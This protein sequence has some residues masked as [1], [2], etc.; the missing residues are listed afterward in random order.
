MCTN[1]NDI[2]MCQSSKWSQPVNDSVSTPLHSTYSKC[3]LIGKPGLFGVFNQQIN[4]IAMNDR[5]VYECL[6]RG[7]ENPFPVKG[8]DK[9][10][11]KGNDWLKLVTTTCPY[12]GYENRRC[13]GHRPEQCVK[14][15]SKFLLY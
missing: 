15:R 2:K 3:P 12:T 7:D 5:K 1:G 14:G 4:S 8:A 10:T 11:W 6:N 9:G 13:L